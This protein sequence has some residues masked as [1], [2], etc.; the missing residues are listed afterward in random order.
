MRASEPSTVFQLLTILFGLAS[1]ASILL[2]IR[3]LVGK[4]WQVMWA[5]A[6]A[7]FVVSIATAMSIGVFILLVTCLQLGAA[8]ALRR[9]ATALGWAV[10]WLGGLAVWLVV[11]PLQILVADRLP[12]SAAIVL[13][14]VIVLW[15]ATPLLPVGRTRARTA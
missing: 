12:P 14:L 6:L 9:K 2:T 1:I 8:V 11:V 15:V 7:S 10:A 4:S 13:V 3:G 5:A